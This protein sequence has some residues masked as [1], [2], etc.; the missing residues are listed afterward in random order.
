MREDRPGREDQLEHTRAGALTTRRSVISN[1]RAI[2]VV[3]AAAIAANLANVTP[4]QARDRGRGDRGH[5]RGHN[6]HHNH[7]HN[8]RHGGR[9]HHHGGGGGSGGGGSAACYLRGTK[10]LTVTGERCIED[11]AIGD[12][13]PTVFGGA[14][15]IEW[16]GSWQYQKRDRAEPW[17]R[18]A[19]PVR[20]VRS[21]LAPGV[22]H[23]DLF[24]TYGHALF[25]DGVLIPAGALINGLTIT[26]DAAA[27]LDQLEYFHIKLATHDVIYAEGAPCES[28]L[29]VDE[30][31]RNHA[32]YQSRNRT[33]EPLDSYCAPVLCSGGG[34]EL[35]SRIRS[36][37]V[38]WVRPQKIDLIRARLEERAIALADEIRGAGPSSGY[39]AA[40]VSG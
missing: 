2:V 24:V 1:A 14:R 37:F 20:I 36:L 8:H 35:K 29:Y 23:A 34:G 30:T 38:P 39:N 4:A 3:A 13:L 31:A 12:W 16:I 18:H 17:K 25:I 32:E 22:P 28:L 27:Q 33:S 9:G 21:A 11:L 15:P 40:I 10:I 7:H 5:G 6:H 19:R 26:L